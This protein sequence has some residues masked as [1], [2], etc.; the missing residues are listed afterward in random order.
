[1]K[2]QLN[3][4]KKQIKLKNWKVMRDKNTLAE[5]IEEILIESFNG[6]SYLDLIELEGGKK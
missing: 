1:M 4:K 6:K 2:I 3:L 5:T